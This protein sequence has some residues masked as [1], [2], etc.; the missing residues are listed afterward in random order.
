MWCRVILKE[1]HHT[2]SFF[3]LSIRVF[4]FLG[5]CSSKR[6]ANRSSSL[7]QK[8]LLIKKI[9]SERQHL[10]PA[11]KRTHTAWFP[12]RANNKAPHETKHTYKMWIMSFEVP[13]CCKKNN[14]NYRHWHTHTHKEHPQADVHMCTSKRMHGVFRLGGGDY[15]REQSDQGTKT[16][17]EWKQWRVITDPNPTHTHTQFQG[18]YRTTTCTRKHTHTHKH[19]LR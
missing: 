1:T 13:H 18:T 7:P 15:A 19:T 11:P 12:N 5:S 14:R 4:F 8:T 10:R 6:S 9:T 17:W 16:T 2:F 3:F